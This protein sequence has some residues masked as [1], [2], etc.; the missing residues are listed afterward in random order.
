MALPQMQDDYLFVGGLLRERIAQV[1]GDQVVVGTSDDLVQ[2]LEKNLARTTVF[3]VW[4][5]EGL[6]D[7]ARGGASTM[8][9][10][11]WIVLLGFKSQRQA[12]GARND[13]A[14]P[15][16]ARLHSAVAGWAP[17][18]VGRPFQRINGGAP[19]YRPG[20]GWYPLTFAIS[21]SL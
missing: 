11:R 14:G 16:L 5:G 3:V 9:A 19:S 21:L 13:E 12:A 17:E 2:V 8:I 15:V 18:G 6:A 4:N 20:V 1:M 7:Q 10:Q